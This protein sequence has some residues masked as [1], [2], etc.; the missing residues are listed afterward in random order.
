MSTI[1][2][3]HH[4]L[5][6]CDAGGIQIHQYATGSLS[7]QLDTGLLIIDVTTRYPYDGTIQLRVQEA[8]WSNASLSLR[9]PAWADEAAVTVTGTQQSSPAGESGRSAGS[10]GLSSPTHP[11]GP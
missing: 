7:A 2:Q 10:P 11:A 4:Y 5:A 1:A 9:I 6:T 8:P 3:L